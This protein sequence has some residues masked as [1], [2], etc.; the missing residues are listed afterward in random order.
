MSARKGPTRAGWAI[1]PPRSASAHINTDIGNGG[2][3]L[4]TQCEAFARDFKDSAPTQQQAQEDAGFRSL[5]EIWALPN[6][7]RVIAEWD[8]CHVLHGILGVELYSQR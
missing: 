2:A 8:G 7:P 6:H 1:T 3:L 5:N 4:Q